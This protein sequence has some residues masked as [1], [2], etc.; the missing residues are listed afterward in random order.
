MKREQRRGSLSTNR[1]QAWTEQSLATAT[2]ARR[3]SPKVRSGLAGD[4]CVRRLRGA[5]FCGWVEK[6]TEAGRRWLVSQGR[7]TGR[8]RDNSWDGQGPCGEMVT[9]GC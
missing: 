6:A 7:Q 4:V 8:V 2:A 9:R 5:W 1:G 3:G